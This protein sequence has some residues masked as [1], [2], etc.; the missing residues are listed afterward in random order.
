MCLRAEYSPLAVNFNIILFCPKK[1]KNKEQFLPKFKVV[2]FW[3]KIFTHEFYH[4][5]K[6]GEMVLLCSILP[7]ES[8]EFGTLGKIDQRFEGLN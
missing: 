8:Y 3:N 5:Q 1:K 6:H 4:L 7:N 2:H